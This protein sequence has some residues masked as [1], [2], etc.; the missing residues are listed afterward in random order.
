M[1]I[2]RRRFLHLAGAAVAVP[3]LPRAAGAQAYPSRTITM[4]VPYA[5]GGP[6]D[7]VGRVVAERMRAELGQAIVLENVSGAAGGLGL[8]RLARAPADGYTIDVRPL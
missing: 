6:T 4:I 1:R 2:P 5:P 7:T 3:A 8:S